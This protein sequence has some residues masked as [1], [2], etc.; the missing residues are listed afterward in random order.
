MVVACLAAMIGWTVGTWEV[1][2]TPV[3]SV[4]AARP[5]AQVYVSKQVPLKFVGPP[6]PFQRATGTIA[7]SPMRSARSAISLVAGQVVSRW[8]SAVVIAQ[9]LLTLAPKTPS[10]RRLSLNNGLLARRASSTSRI[11]I[12][13]L[14][15]AAFPATARAPAG[16]EPALRASRPSA[17]G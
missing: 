12:R 13:P 4:A 1:E 8:P 3:C 2:K 16:G 10:L 7:S 17:F 14:P 5:A 9:P 11:A 6:N 15:L